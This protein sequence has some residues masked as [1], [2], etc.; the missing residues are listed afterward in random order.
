MS[1]TMKNIFMQKRG[2]GGRN[3]GLGGAK[4]CIH[5]T[6]T[7]TMVK[8]AKLQ[9]IQRQVFEQINLV[10]NIYTSWAYSLSSR[11]LKGK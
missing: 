5:Q 3:G 6:T 10:Y 7:E 1:Q 11:G 8:V 9:S 4:R 2:R